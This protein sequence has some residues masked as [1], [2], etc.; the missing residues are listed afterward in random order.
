[1]FRVGIVVRVGEMVKKAFAS[2]HRLWSYL[3]QPDGSFHCLYL[4]EEGPDV[5]EL[6]MSPVL[7]QASGLRGDLPLVRMQRPPLVHVLAQFID[8]WGGIILLRGGRNPLAFV[9]NECL[10]SNR[11]FLLLR[12]RDRRNEL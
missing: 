6:V 9:E 8:D 5:V 12:L 10:L 1:E 7:E 2:P 3:D 4:A 11:S